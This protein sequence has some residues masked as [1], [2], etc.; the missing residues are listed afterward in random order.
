MVRTIVYRV[1]NVLLLF[2]CTLHCNAQEKRRNY[3]QLSDVRLLESPFKKAQDLD[4]YY[5]LEMDIDR[6]LAPY[7]REAGLSKKAESY[8][9]WEVLHRYRIGK[10]R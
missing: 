1:I 8:S 6:L 7:R 4:R 2:S 5:M 3:F 10:P 9:N